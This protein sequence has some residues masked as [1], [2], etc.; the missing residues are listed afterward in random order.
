M[1]HQCDLPPLLL[2]FRGNYEVHLNSEDMHVPDLALDKTKAHGGTMVMWHTSLS[3]FI[4][5]LPSE[6]PS[7]QSILLKLPGTIPSI[8]T[9]LYLPTSGKE[10]EFLSSL[11]ELGAHMDEIRSK[12]PDAA[13]FLRGDAN[14]NPNNAAR[15][16][17][18]SYFCSSF[19]LKNVPLNHPT[20][21]HFV[22]NGCFDSEIDVILFFGTD[23]K[24]SEHLVNIVCKLDS[25]FVNSQHDAILSSCK[26]PKAPIPPPEH[27]LVQ[28]PRIPNERIKIIWCEDG[29][30]EYEAL[31]STNLASLRKLWGNSQ[32]RSS[33]SVLLSS[34]YS[35][36]SFAAKSTN[37]FIDLASSKSPKP[38]V[39]PEIRIL[40][41]NVLKAKNHLDHIL[42]SSP[43]PQA[44]E[45]AKE[46][47]QSARATLR[48]SVRAEKSTLRDQRDEEL[49]GILSSNP[50]AV[51]RSIKSAKGSAS[52]SIHN[53]KVNGKVYSGETVPDG[54]YDS[55]SSLK[56]PDLSTLHSSTHYQETLMDYENVL[57]IA[58]EGSKIPSISPIR[59]TEI[60]HALRANVND[61]YSITANHFINAG[62]DGLEHFHFLLNIIIEEVNLS[63]LEELN[64]IWACILYK[65]HRKDKESDRSYR[66][67]STCPLFAKALDLY[68]G[69][70]YYDGWA[71]AQAETQFQGAGSSHELAGLLL[72]ES[73]NFSLFSL[74]QPVFILLLDAKSAFDLILRE[75]IIVNAFK[76]GSCDQGLLYLDNRL[77]SRNTY[78]EWNKQLMG[79]I[80]DL[81][82]VEQGGINSDKLYKLA[83]NNQL[84]VAQQSKLGVDLGSTVVSSIGLADDSALLANDI[85]SLNNLLL[86]TLEYCQKYSVTLVPEKTKL[87]AFCPSGSEQVVDYAKIISPINING[88]FIPFSESAEHVGVVRSILGNGANILSRLSAHRRAVFSVLPAGLARGHRGN[89][90]AGMRV[91]RLYG[92]PVLL[93]GLATMVFSKA[94]LAQIAGHFKQHVER[95]L[96]L[97]KA[98]PECVVWFLG[99]CLPIQALLHLHQ[100]SLFGM[101]T[102][103]NDGNNILANHARNMFASAKP[104]SKSWFLQVQEIFLQ[105]SLPHPITF[106]NNPLSKHSFKRLTKSAILD[107]WEQKLRGEAIMLDSLK[108][109]HPS[110]MSLSTTHPIF[111]TCG[112]SP[113]Q[114]SK[115][116][117]QARYLSGRGRVEA[118]TK[119]W[120]MANKDGICPLCK[121]IKPTL[122]T[123]EHLLLSG[124]C[125]ALVEARLTMLSFFQ[126]YMVS[127][128][129]LLPLMQACWDTDDSTTMQLLLD[130]S[131]IPIIIKKAQESN[132]PIIKDIFY[133][134]RTYVFK[135]YTSRRRLLL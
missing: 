31:V 25:P 69:E 53:L 86:L 12:Y 111:S 71:E 84:E 79:P 103:L 109:F 134:T 126:A 17:L 107:H 128:P 100:I 77:R 76:A 65:G 26:L 108:Y 80:H 48:Q 99:G 6:S 62:F 30:E 8:H 15:Y 20:Y 1:L 124:G 24:V 5:V 81:L 114:V 40:E 50:S 101:I 92:T 57:K 43:T 85:H 9:A 63:S 19:S 90:A 130:C 21:H 132:D 52:S 97:H 104:S 23:D 129:Y 83:N 75:N 54:F 116:G 38:Q 58:R 4:T 45:H 102:R 34:T 87:L 119:H 46:K 122:G 98:T 121:E 56:S 10:E 59:S 113:Y 89:P 93:S 29:I 95:L 11:V 35:C 96:K 66:T 36:L 28:A 39:S 106:L 73:I 115:A 27:Q 18:F 22:G 37:K 13:L 78:C 123:L 88:D 3:P 72:T 74:K 120:D 125:P 105:Y 44:I 135:I 16:S 42:T 68:V 51:F 14:A 91:E 49:S 33:I 118:L 110:Y 112:S 82:G 70:L 64:T 55:L 133:M 61:F 67:I 60:L 32:S 2:P 117:V 7:Y 41:R 131:A 94:E 47:L 127:R